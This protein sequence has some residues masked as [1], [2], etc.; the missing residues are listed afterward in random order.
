M[1]PKIY[2]T[3]INPRDRTT[4]TTLLLSLIHEIV[5]P[6]EFQCFHKICMRHSNFTVS[7]FSTVLHALLPKVLYFF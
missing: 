5:F 4:L 7:K 6:Q 2:F 1:F 3:A